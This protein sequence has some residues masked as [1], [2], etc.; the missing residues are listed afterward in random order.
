MTGAEF[1]AA[2]DALGLTQKEMATEL[3]MGRWGWQTIIGWEAERK[4]V[5]ALTA[6]VVERLVSERGAL[7]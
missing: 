1:K 7:A 2:R 3:H 4:P 5:P 6:M